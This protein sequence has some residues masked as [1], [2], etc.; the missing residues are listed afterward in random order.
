[1]PEIADIPYLQARQRRGACFHAGRSVAQADLFEIEW[2]G[3]PALLKDFSGRPWVVRRVWG[4]VIIARE[5]RALQRMAGVAGFPALYVTA[6]PEAFIMERLDA[7]RM[8]PKRRAPPPP[9][10]WENAR[11]I[12]D[13]LHRHGI[14]HGDLRR[15]NILIGPRG[16]AYLIDFAT[17]FFRSGGAGIGGRISEAI[18][19]RY[20]RIDR[21]T[22]ARIK[23]TY[24]RVENLTDEE[25]EWLAAEP[26][27]LKVGRF[28]KQH[29]YA[30]RRAQTWRKG[31][32]KLRRRWR[33]K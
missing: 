21:V 31:Y 6:G 9:V 32:K 7:D 12:I 14:G 24:T 23:A 22:Y 19:R 10:F 1:M 11:A 20:Q 3:R 18:F 26:W 30:L 17:A 2:E 25:R 16:E 4:R 8:P 29:V 13:E 5:I 33:A 28:L 15:K 27:Y